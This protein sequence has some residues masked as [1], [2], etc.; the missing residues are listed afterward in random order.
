MASKKTCEETVQKAWGEVR[1]A[2][3]NMASGPTE[4]RLDGE[5]DRAREAI[6]QIQKFRRILIQ[7]GA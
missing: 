4:E 3:D 5:A 7:E 6:T 2:A 1:A